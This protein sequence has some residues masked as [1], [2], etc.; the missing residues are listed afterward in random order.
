M[1][2]DQK[3]LA[4]KAVY[5]TLGAPVVM[6]RKVRGLGDKIAE[7]SD[8]VAETAQARFDDY[9]REGEKVAKQI[10][11]SDV[12]EEIQHRVDLD[13][14]T[15]R[16]ER[17]RDQLEAAMQSWRESFTPG[18]AKTAARKVVVEAEETVKAAATPTKTTAARKPTAKTTTR[19]TT[20]KTTPARTTAPK[21]PAKT[22]TT[23]A[24]TAPRAASTK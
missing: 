10:R 8:K 17:L 5:A 21:A 16:V 4:T 13:K 2:N 12:V 7:Y 11:R 15:D 3:E 19:K 18:D 14:V 6:A 1:M 22:S 23:K 9:A 24:T 20:A